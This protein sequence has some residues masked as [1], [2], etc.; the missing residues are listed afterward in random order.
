MAED[1]AAWW[2]A[3]RQGPA[4]GQD[5]HDVPEVESTC[6]G[7]CRCAQSAEGES[8][9]GGLLCGALLWPALDVLRLVQAAWRRYVADAEMLMAQP[10]QR[11]VR[12]PADL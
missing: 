9:L 12:S 6:A 10:Q 5:S 8:F 11:R 2:R 7:L 4:A 1:F 3:A